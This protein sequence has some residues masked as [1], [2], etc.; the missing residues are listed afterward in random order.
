MNSILKT[1]YEAAWR[2]HDRVPPFRWLVHVLYRASG[3]PCLC[4]PRADVL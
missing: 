1:N 2:L 4:R 3:D